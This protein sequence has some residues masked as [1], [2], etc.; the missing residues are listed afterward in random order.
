MNKLT[1]INKFRDFYF[2]V[3]LENFRL[4][5]AWTQTVLEQLIS[6]EN[7]W[8]NIPRSRDLSR[9]ACDWL[10][11]MKNGGKFCENIFGPPSRWLAKENVVLKS[12]ECR[13]SSCKHMPVEIVRGWSKKIKKNFSLLSFIAVKTENKLIVSVWKKYQK[14]DSKVISKPWCIKVHRQFN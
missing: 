3:G 7:I 6:T 4:Y 1:K 10:K 12:V 13:K 8:F 5:R 11:Q 2:V 14:E 9:L